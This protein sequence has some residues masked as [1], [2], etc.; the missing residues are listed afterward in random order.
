MP[1]IWKPVTTALATVQIRGTVPS[2]AVIAWIW[3]RRAGETRHHIREAD[4]VG[5]RGSTHEIAEHDSTLPV[6]TS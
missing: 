2:A 5:H 4:A 3:S 1:V 6:G